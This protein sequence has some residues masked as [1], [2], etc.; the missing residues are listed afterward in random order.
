VWPIGQIH[1][2]KVK[3]HL[4]PGFMVFGLLCKTTNPMPPNLK[5]FQLLDKIAYFQNWGSRSSV[6]NS[7]KGALLMSHG[8][9]C[10]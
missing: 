6:Q 10:D 7:L 2:T 1:A 8:N 3:C 5:A 9:L 4:I